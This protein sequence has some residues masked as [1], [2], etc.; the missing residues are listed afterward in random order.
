MYTYIV[1]ILIKI[2]TEL[3]VINMIRI[4]SSLC[5]SSFANVLF[6]LHEAA[7]SSLL[8][9]EGKVVSWLGCFLCLDKN[10]IFPDLLNLF[11]FFL[12]L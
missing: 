4:S 7:N 8:L 10:K 12:L 5:Y 3:L 9:F 2:I 11:I 6:E 1:A